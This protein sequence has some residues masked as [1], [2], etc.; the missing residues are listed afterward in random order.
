MKLKKRIFTVLLSLVM[1]LTVAMPVMAD[2]NETEK[3]KVTISNAVDGQEYSLWRIF[4]LA[5]YSETAKAYVYTV[6]ASWKDFINQTNISGTGGFVSV[7]ANGYV[8]WAKTDEKTKKETGM[9]EFAELALAWAKANNILAVKEVSSNS[10][11]DK[12]VSVTLNTTGDD[13]GTFKIEIS[14]LELG[15]YLLESNVGTLLSLDTAAPNVMIRDKNKQ[16]TLEKQVQENSKVQDEE[17]SWGDKNDAQ[18]GDTVNF[19]VTITAQAGAQNYILHEKMDDGLTFNTGSVEVRFTRKGEESPTTLTNNKEYTLITDRDK[20]I[21]GEKDEDVNDGDE[22]EDEKDCT[23]HVE[24]SDAFC[25]SL[26]ADD[27]IEVTYSA[28]L[29]EKVDVVQGED[30]TAYL[31]YGE[32]SQLETKPDETKTYTYQFQLIKTN[33][34]VNGEG[35]YEILQGAE[36]ELYDAETGGNKIPLVAVMKPKPNEK[37]VDYYRVATKT[38]AEEKDFTSAVI[39]AGTPIIKGLDID[40]ISEKYKSYWLEEIKAPEGYKLPTERLEV[41]LTRNSLAEEGSI[42][43]KKKDNVVIG[44]EWD[45]SKEGGVQVTN[46]PGSMLPSTGGIGTTI[47]YVVGCILV[48]GAGIA[49]VLMSRRTK[50]NAKR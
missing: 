2:G 39:V 34:T 43:D 10:T 9:K 32:D 16:P 4:D 35:K 38:E 44:Q 27:K 6:N 25:D 50:K 8:T 36:F 11:D 13:A 46:T 17:K 3:G 48:I 7:D 21:H 47:F 37:E 24:F 14:G 45:S 23:F 1:A 5:S 30:N 18:I 19:K 31:S 26:K 49:L 15:Y 29:N 41:K 28:V 40:K 42:T 22:D 33:N 20:L 12:N